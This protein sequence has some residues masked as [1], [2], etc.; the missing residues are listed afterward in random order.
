MAIEPQPI[1]QIVS[2][3]L[4][5]LYFL[6][7]TASFWPQAV[8]I[9]RRKSVAGVSLDFLALNAFGFL[10]Y[11]IFNLS[12]LV[13]RTIQ[14]QYRNTHNGQENLVRW[15]DAFFAIHAF[16]IASWQLG[17]AFY[18]K[19]EP[20]QKISTPARSLLG[21]C[22][23]VFLSAFATCIVGGGDNDSII[24]WIDFVN[25]CSYIKLLITLTKYTVSLLSAP[26]S[27]LISVATNPSEHGTTIYFRLC[28]RRD[29]A[30]PHRRNLQSHPVGD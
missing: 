10:C 26:L 12:F 22:I 4:G 9:Y 6:A 25:L 27:L 11:G 13:S 23:T 18:Y 29:S 7:W 30:G 1:W 17:A 24:R 28:H 20:N 14:Q 21:A 5:W 8:L 2:G 15:N 16:L 19:R 3:A